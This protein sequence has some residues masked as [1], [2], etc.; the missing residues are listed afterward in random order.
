MGATFGDEAGSAS[1]EYA[2]AT[3]NSLC[4]RRRVW[5]TI[6]S[7]AD[8]GDQVDPADTGHRQIQQQQVELIL[9]W[10]I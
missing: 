8:A 3:C 1:L 7:Q 9:C 5:V 10:R 4:M 2:L 6:S